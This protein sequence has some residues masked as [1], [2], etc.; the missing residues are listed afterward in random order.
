VEV[1]K[2]KP[3]RPR[4]VTLA[5]AEQA[6]QTIAPNFEIQVSRQEKAHENVQEKLV[7]QPHGGSLMRQ[8]KDP[9]VTSY[10]DP[11]EFLQ[12]VYRGEVD[13][14][15][16]QITAAKAMLPFVHKRIGDEGKKKEKQDAA[17][18]VSDRF[19]NAGAPPKLVVNGGRSI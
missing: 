2:R 18:Q 3:G 6:G 4:K 12:A 10:T 15:N 8:R 13:A 7:K 17:K 11:L 1:T 5:E 14:T 19:S 9:A 16:A